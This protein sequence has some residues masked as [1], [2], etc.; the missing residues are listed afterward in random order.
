[1]QTLWV[2][3]AMPAALDPAKHMA[4]ES[5]QDF[6]QNICFSFFTI[7]VL[8]E[9]KMRLARILETCLFAC[10]FIFRSLY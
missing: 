2:N 9:E 8:R 4:G 10:L 6:F 1:M 3:N 5:S 7:F